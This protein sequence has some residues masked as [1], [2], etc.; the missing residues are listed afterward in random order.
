MFARAAGGFASGMLRQV[1]LIGAPLALAV[2]MWIH[3]H[4]GEAVYGNVVPVVDTFLATHLAAYLLFGSL[5]VALVSLLSGERSAVA[6]V[7]RIGVG[8]YAGLYLGMVAVLGV[9]TGLLVRSARNLPADQQAGVAEVVNALHA[10]PL[11]VGAGVLGAV[12]Y[13]IAVV[14][15][16]VVLRRRGAPRIPLALLVA[17]VVGIGAHSGPAAIAGM[18]S[19][20]VAAAWLEFGWRPDGGAAGASDER[21]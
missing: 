12:G 7:A 14:A 16:A 20:A 6:T 9:G 15:V 13:L 21:S 11:V 10:D 8:A 4:T 5:G 17:S 18:A 2:V 3:P 19:F 1:V